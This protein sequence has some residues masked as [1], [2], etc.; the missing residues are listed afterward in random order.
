MDQGVETG[1]QLHLEARWW[2]DQ[3]YSQ[4]NWVSSYVWPILF[5]KLLSIVHYVTQYNPPHHFITSPPKNIFTTFPGCSANKWNLYWEKKRS[6]CGASTCIWLNICVCLIKGRSHLENAGNVLFA[7]CFVLGL[8]GIWMGVGNSNAPSWPLIS[9]GTICP[10][11]H[12]RCG[13]EKERRKF[14]KKVQR[15]WNY[16]LF[17]AVFI[18]NILL[19][20][21][22]DH[23]K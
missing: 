12:R 8:L 10:F 3:Y 1:G 6:N 4:H 17:Y 13:L 7:L 23:Q 14:Q 22:D 18:H 9:F 2:P 19:H 11:I 20:S 5:T 16:F 21:Y 15:S